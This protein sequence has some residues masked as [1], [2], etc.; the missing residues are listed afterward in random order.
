MTGSPHDFIPLFAEEART[1]LDALD[2]AL[3]R[4]EDQPDD[5]AAIRA[6][7]Q[8]VHS[9][10]GGAAM[11]DLRAPQQL[12]SAFEDLLAHLRAGRPPPD[13]WLEAAFVARDQLIRQLGALAPGTPPHPDDERATHALRALLTPPGPDPSSGAAEV[14][15]ADTVQPDVQPPDARPPDVRAPDARTPESGAASQDTA[16]ALAAPL[17]GASGPDARAP[18]APA[19]GVPDASGAA[20]RTA[21]GGRALLQALVL[22][23]SALSRDVLARH[24]RALGYDV[25]TH[26]HVPA[27]TG[28]TLVLV[29]AALLPAALEAGWPAR[30]LHVLS[31]DPQRRADAHARG[32]S[33]SARPAH[34]T[35]PQDLPPRWTPDLP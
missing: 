13:A 32:L 2:A 8:A 20:P 5:P 33:V 29:S 24:L 10:K 14:S 28:A 11:L 7:F 30:A 19:P 26:G 16:P 4:L 25:H 35:R 9:I 34:D 21:P 27:P 15:R 23:V 1:Q 6:A 31:E 18:V 3:H 12:M 22:D 17:P